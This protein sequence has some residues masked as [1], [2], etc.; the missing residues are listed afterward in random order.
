MAHTSKIKALSK[1]VSYKPHAAV[2]FPWLCQN[3]FSFP[4]SPHC[5]TC[6]M[7]FWTVKSFKISPK[8]SPSFL[9]TSGCFY[10]LRLIH[11]LEWLNLCISQGP[12]AG[13]NRCV[14][15]IS[16]EHQNHPDFLKVEEALDERASCG[17][18]CV[19]TRRIVIVQDTVRLNP[20]N[21]NNEL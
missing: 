16:T 8:D 5:M 1:E 6:L 3:S 10:N 19:S 7:L 9:K 20:R 13:E 17:D 14:T 2:G 12:L 18:L 21:K 4:L 11:G 15:Q